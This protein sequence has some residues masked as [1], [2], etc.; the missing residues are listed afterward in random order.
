M[1]SIKEYWWRVG[2]E[3]R[4][5]QH[6]GDAFQD[7][8]GRI[9]QAR[10]GDDYVRVRP[11]GQRGDKG[12]DG[13]LAS[14]GRV[15]QCYGAVNG[16]GGKVA[17]LVGKMEEDFAKAHDALI[18][19]MKEWRMVHNLVDGLPVEAVQALNAIQA[20][21]PSIPCGFVGLESIGTILFDLDEPNIEALI[22]PAATFADE[23]NFQAA[24]LKGLVSAILQ[25]V[26]DAPVP[27]LAE[28]KEVSA[29]KLAHNALPQ[30]WAQFISAGW[31][32]AHHVSAYFARHP[33]PLTGERVAQR[34]RER[35]AYLRAQGL[36]APPIMAALYEMIVG[37]GIVPVERMIAAQAL[38]AHLFESCDI[39]EDASVAQAV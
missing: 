19:I 35:Y 9:M 5:R 4:L 1:D 38:L 6:S 13:Y 7:L 25:A 23:Q 39:L 3:L 22:G 30:H 11:F 10:H 26:D 31:Q 28:I 2:L 24:E 37:K 27:S 12:C 15:Y 8:F 16:E 34:F 33:D 18:D 20:S 21:H 32:N 14:C 36:K 29:A 17:Y